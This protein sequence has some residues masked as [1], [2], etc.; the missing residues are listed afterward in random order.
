M[1]KVSILMNCYNSD[2]YLKESI[3]S[4][5]SQSYSDWEIIFWDNQSTDNSA[6][7]IKKY[8]DKR[9]KY[10]Y[11][12]S[13]TSL[14]IGRS[15]ALRHC[16]GKYLAFLDCDDLWMID[17]LEEQVNIFENN[18]KVALVHSNTIFFN[19]DTK[20]EKILNSKKRISG[21]IFE[22]NIL[23]YQF[24]LETVMVRMS[25]IVDNSINFGDFNM[26]GD[27][28][29]LSMVC[30]YGDVHYID[31]ILGKWRIHANN[32]SKVLHT[33]YPKEL[34]KMHLRF[35]NKFG[36]RFTKKMRSRLY[37]EIVLREALN[38]F[39]YSGIEV[40]NKL[41]KIYLLEPKS[42]ILRF[43]SYLPTSIALKV[44]NLAKKS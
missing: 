7:I 38:S 16:E 11:A 22:E 33:G 43:L 37:V 2:L 14:Y 15:L 40:R 13:H 6:D 9:I 5:M 39:L 31:K 17:K 10:F 24:S 42:I 36:E 20:K 34:K 26:I 12:P 3:D 44:L 30:F 27:R 21:Y 19:S 8:N 25:T 4:V 41:Q 29:F 32:F 1:A 18:K 28:D 35:K 23:N